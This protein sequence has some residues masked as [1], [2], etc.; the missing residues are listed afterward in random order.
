L[1]A[2][3]VG[4]GVS[5][6]ATVNATAAALAAKAATSTIPIVFTIGADPV[7][8][9]LVASLNRPGGNVTGVSFLSNL[10]VAKQLGLLQEFVPAASGFGL[11]VNPSNPNADSD[12]RQAKAAAD[13]LGR[14]IHV[15]YAST[16]RD[17]GTAFA[18]LIERRVAALVVVPDALF[19]GQREQ[20]ATLAA[21]HAI[22]TIYSNRAYADAGGLM[23][24]GASQLDA[25]RQAGI[26]VGRILSGEKPADL[27]VIQPTRFEL[28]VNLKTARALHLQVPDKL[29]A[30]ADEVI[31]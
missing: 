5:V 2:E 28:V 14:E 20:L 21:R 30:L 13:S 27:P 23:S 1:A 26:Y 17:L 18:A 31:E 22:P 16:E 19:V 12:T 10:L 11:L 15:V 4:K 8:F 6:I 9:G 25:Y 3:L 7:Q 29:L 24:Y